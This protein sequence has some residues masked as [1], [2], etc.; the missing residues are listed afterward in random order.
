MGFQTNFNSLEL[1]YHFY[2]IGTDMAPFL[3]ILTVG[4]LM[5]IITIPI[6]VMSMNRQQASGCS[7]HA[8]VRQ[9]AS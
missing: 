9:G 6:D 1:F 7:K 2:L 5:R 4:I 3:Q 8:V